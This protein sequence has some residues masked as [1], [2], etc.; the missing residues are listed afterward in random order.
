M[1]I[2]RALAQLTVR[3]LLDA[4]GEGKDGQQREEHRS[5]FPA[6]RQHENTTE[7]KTALTMAPHASG[8]Y[9]QTGRFE[10]FLATCGSELPGW[11][12]VI[13]TFLSP[14]TIY[15]TGSFLALSLVLSLS[16]CVCVCARVWWARLLVF[17]FVFVFVF[18]R[19]RVPACVRARA[20]VRACVRVHLSLPPPLSPFLSLSLCVALAMPSLPL[21]LS[22]L[23]I[24]ILSI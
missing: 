17:V 16:L 2:I 3:G 19:A 24:K 23:R 20:R 1:L 22:L 12:G 4:Q 11:T 18:V 15:R 21:S 7:T 9:K 10:Q 13:S 5:C 14:F 6:K 8:R